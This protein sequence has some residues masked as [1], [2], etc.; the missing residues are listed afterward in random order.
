MPE[1]NDHLPLYGPGPL[2]VGVIVALTVAGIALSFLGVVPMA[3]PG[4][5]DIPLTAVGLALVAGGAALW[6]AANFK[7]RIDDG[8]V[9]NRLVTGGVYAV[10]RNPIYSAF[11]LACTGA[12][13]IFGN[14][15]LLVLPPVF[16]AFLTVLMKATEEKWLLGLYGAEY[17]DY[18]RR[19]N[20]CIPW[21]PRR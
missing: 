8:I 2:Y 20:R 14:L 11:A 18:C 6:W 10:V 7:A 12:I 21:I 1:A 13:L 16:W 4:A 17:D 19:V 3:R 15:W 5:A 9:G